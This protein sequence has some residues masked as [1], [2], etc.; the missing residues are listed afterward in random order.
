MGDDENDYQ[1][2]WLPKNHVTVMEEED[3]PI[4]TV[5]S[6]QDDRI[7]Q[8]NEDRSV[9]KRKRK[10]L[11]WNYPTFGDEFLQILNDFIKRTDQQDLIT[12]C[13]KESSF[14]GFWFERKFFSYHHHNQVLHVSCISNNEDSAKDITF[15][16]ISVKRLDEG[17][18][19][20]NVLYELKRAHPIVD[21]VG[22]LTDDGNIEWLVF[23]QISLQ[24]YKDHPKKLSKMFNCN[25]G[26]PVNKSW[27]LYTHYRHAYDIDYRSSSIRA[28]LL[29]VSPSQSEVTA[30][31]K[32]S[33]QRVNIHQ[34]LR[35]GVYQ[36]GSP[37][38]EEMERFEKMRR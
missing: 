32:E 22:H 25:S 16:N 30:L 18:L 2:T 15:N 3:V 13:Q 8:T 27:S 17:S 29:Y 9:D 28:L 36:V 1:T 12:V 26:N 21:C 34:P 33:I 10:I 5:P 23:V 31:M 35:V 24:P 6:D 4:L 19:E 11:R 7:A 38:Y 14:A 37:Y 20:K